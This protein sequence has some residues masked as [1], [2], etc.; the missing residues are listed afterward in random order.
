MQFRG[1]R[2]QEEITKPDGKSFLLGSEVMTEHES[3][4]Y[5]DY[6]PAFESQLGTYFCT[7]MCTNFAVENQIVMLTK[8]KFGF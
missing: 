7:S 4:D 6:L 2:P 3:C 5:R 8:V 1:L